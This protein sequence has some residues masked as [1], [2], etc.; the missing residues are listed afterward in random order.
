MSDDRCDIGTDTIVPLRREEVVIGKRVVAGDVVRVA[1]VT[2][3]REQRVEVALMHER[4]VIEHVPVGRIVAEAPPVRQVGDVTI[5]PVIEEV[6]VLERRLLLK[7]EV[8]IRRVDEIERRVETVVLHAQTAD[9]TRRP[10]DDAGAAPQSPQ[11]ETS[12]MTNETIVAVYDDVLSTEAAC[13]DLA[14]AGVPESAISWTGAPVGATAAHATAAREPGFWHRLFGGEPDHDTAVYDRSV[15]GGASVLTVHAPAAD[16]DRIVAI[17]ERH[18]PIDIEERAAGYGSG[19]DDAGIG[20]GGRA[21]TGIR[22]DAGTHTGTDTGT[23]TVYGSGEAVMPLSEER[24]EVGR[25]LVDRGTTRVRRFV[26]ETPV[27]ADVT[28]HAERVV[29]ERRPATAATTAAAFTDQVV[30]MRESDEEAVVGKTAHVAE[31]IVLR[32]VGT[33]RVE[34]VHDTVRREE[35]EITHDDAVP[36]ASARR[37]I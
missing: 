7:E 11:K 21:R 24:I 25:R 36:G 20:M 2:Q 14:A 29:V 33:D 37:G 22:T 27:T 5:M 30:E 15:A 1:T 16:V 6:L 4:V 17:M 31:E 10:A 13:A 26:V 35:V 12:D 34:T 32:K 28:L 23:D 8:H 19:P 18:G 3:L 9:V